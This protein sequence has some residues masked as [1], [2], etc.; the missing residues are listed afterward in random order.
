MVNWLLSRFCSRIL[1][2]YSA[3]DVIACSKYLLSDDSVKWQL[4][5]GKC[6]VPFS[7]SPF[8][9]SA[10]GCASV[11]THSQYSVLTLHFGPGSCSA[12]S[13]SASLATALRHYP[14]NKQSRL[15][16]LIAPAMLSSL[17]AS[18]NGLVGKWIKWLNAP[19]GSVQCIGGH[20]H[21]YA[22][23]CMPIGGWQ[24]DLDV[25]IT[26]KDKPM[27]KKQAVLCYRVAF[28]WCNSI[29]KIEL[30]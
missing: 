5:Q 2:V 11:T 3:R 4:L 30:E 15:M 12:W 23:H 27:N 16:L 9:L 21:G 22:T 7:L 20:G 24:L 13:C 8:I 29:C 25:W 26:T 18:S 10:V 1:K 14:P 28:I 19:L 17:H 6:D